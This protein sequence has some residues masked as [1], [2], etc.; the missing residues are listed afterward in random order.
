[1]L[2]VVQHDQRLTVANERPQHAFRSGVAGEQPEP[3]DDHVGDGTAGDDLGEV[4]EP[5]AVGEPRRLVARRLDRQAG[6]PAPPGSGD[7]GQ[8]RGPERTR[9]LG[10]LPVAPD[11]GSRPGRQVPRGGRRDGGRRL[12]D[13][14]LRHHRP[15]ELLELA[16]GLEPELVAQQRAHPPERR[17]G[18]LGASEIREG[19]HPQ[20]PEALAERVVELERFEVDQHPVGTAQR[21]QRGQPALGDLAAQLLEPGHDGGG[22]GGVRDDLVGRAPPQA[23]RLLAVPQRRGRVRVLAGHRGE[24]FEPPGVDVVRRDREP[25]ATGVA[26]EARCEGAGAGRFEDAAQAP[27][28]VLHAGRAGV[29]VVSP[30]GD[31]QVL[32]GHPPV[33]VDRQR[34][35]DRGLLRAGTGSFDAVGLHQEWAQ[36]AHPHRPTLEPGSPIT[37]HPVGRTRSRC[38]SDRPARRRSSR[39][40]RARAGTA[41]APRSARRRPRPR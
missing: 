13:L 30:P 11:Q 16:P 17:E 32:D 21:Q 9:E 40:R 28:V 36:V 33:G 23:Q 29:G 20:G 39:T 6:L 26:R 35:E 37:H 14:L 18:L 3:R 4:D 25:V 34:R 24:P 19:G 10:Q 2:A 15:V 12:G 7:R 1:M 8:G 31:H 22:G 5:D 38:V 41:R 27:E